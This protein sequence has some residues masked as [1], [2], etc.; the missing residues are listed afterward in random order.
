M[1][2]LSLLSFLSAEW[3]TGQ[4]QAIIGTPLLVPEPRNVIFR[5]GNSTRKNN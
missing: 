4:G 3:Q 1:L 5:E 2:D